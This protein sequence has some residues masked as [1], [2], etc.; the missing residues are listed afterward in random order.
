MKTILITIV[1]VIAGYSIQA[2]TFREVRSFNYLDVDASAQ[3]NEVVDH[4]GFT[5]KVI[6]IQIKNNSRYKTLIGYKIRFT[7]YDPFGEKIDELAVIYSHLEHAKPGE[8]LM[9]HYKLYADKH[10]N[11][12]SAS[13]DDYIEHEIYDLAWK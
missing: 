11:F 12:V 9:G 10:Y 2:Q 8:T 13:N 5:G 7:I 3:L 1:I 4:K 6:N